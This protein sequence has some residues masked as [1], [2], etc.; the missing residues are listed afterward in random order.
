MPT[1]LPARKIK[2]AM[3]VN[4]SAMRRSSSPAFAT[5]D[6]PPPYPPVNQAARDNDVEKMVE[7]LEKGANIDQPDNIDGAT[8]LMNACRY[9]QPDT[10]LELIRRGANVEPAARSHDKPI[11]WAAVNGMVEV[12]RALIL[13]GCDLNLEVNGRKSIPAYARDF[14]DRHPEFY[15]MVGEA[16]EERDRLIAAAA[17]AEAEKRAKAFSDGATVLE[18]PLTVAKP[19]TLKR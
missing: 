16:I 1:K 7:L 10:A 19:I 2:G 8:P 17:A 18:Q 9:N 13:K 3:P 12:G 5:Q 4:D 15:K 14:S 6:R 11:A